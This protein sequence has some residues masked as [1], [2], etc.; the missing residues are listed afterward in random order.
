MVSCNGM[1]AVTMLLL[2]KEMATV[3]NST[4]AIIFKI[5]VMIMQ[6]IIVPVII[7]KVIIKIAITIM[8]MTTVKTYND[9]CRK[10]CGINNSYNIITVII[11]IT[12]IV[13]N[14]MK[15]DGDGSRNKGNDHNNSNTCERYRYYQE[16]NK[17]WPIYNDG[18]NVDYIS[19]AKM[20]VT[21][22]MMETVINVDSDDYYRGGKLTIATDIG[23]S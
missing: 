11:N 17:D 20:P 15:S 7:V 22:I 4:D 12:V 3:N 5:I 9:N 2:V 14:I 10:G 16:S 8:I 21:V 13:I 23:V 1:T 6:I 19:L 18:K